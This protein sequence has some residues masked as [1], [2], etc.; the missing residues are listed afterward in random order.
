MPLVYAN[1]IYDNIIIP[2][3]QTSPLIH[4]NKWEYT[5]RVNK[6]HTV[7]ICLKFK[8]LATSDIIGLFDKKILLKAYINNTKI[9]E[10]DIHYNFLFCRN[11]I[12]ITFDIFM[13]KHHSLS[14]N[15]S[16]ETIYDIYI[17]G[18]I[19]THSSWIKIFT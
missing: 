2:H 14:F 7:I 12:T 3:E 13:M 11:T 9:R 19:N 16:N 1:E 18:Y 6:L 17:S 10:W 15:I 5:S 4:T 8:D